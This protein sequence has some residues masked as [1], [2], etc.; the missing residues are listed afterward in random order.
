MNQV[1][2]D[3]DQLATAIHQAIVRMHPEDPTQTVA[4]SLSGWQ[5]QRFEDVQSTAR[6]L[7]DGAASVLNGPNPLIIV[8]EHDR[9]KAVGHAMAVQ[10][11]QRDD[12]ICIDSVQTGGGDFIDI[13]TPVGAGRAVPVVVKTLVF[14][15]RHGGEG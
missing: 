9:A 7:I 11:G 8:L 1:E 6:A 5:I 4:V 10:R 14:N 2:G 12:V 13:G 15:D 3:P